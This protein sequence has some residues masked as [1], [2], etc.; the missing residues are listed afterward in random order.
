MKKAF[1]NIEKSTSSDISIDNIVP[2]YYYIRFLPKNWAEYDLL[3]KDSTLTLYEIPLDYEIVS[4]GYFYHDPELHDTAI[5]WQ[6]CAVKVDKMLPEVYYELIEELYIPPINDAN[7]SEN[8]SSKFEMLEE[9]AF[10]ITGNFNQLK[11]SQASEWRPA[12]RIRVWDTEVGTYVPV[13]G[14]IVRAR[15][16]FTTHKGTTAEDGTFSCDGKF[17]GDANYS[18]E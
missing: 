3:K 11:S 14:L 10:R 13:K 9:E 1:E 4:P 2:N 7:N 15:R 17:K 16:W 12:G 6:Y 18:F 5:T 8:E